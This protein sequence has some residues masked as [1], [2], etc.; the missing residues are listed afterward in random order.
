MKFTHLVEINT[1]LLPL[2]DLLSRTQLWN[3]LVLRMQAP[4]LFV[5]YLDDCQIS[6]QTDLHFARTLRFGEVRI[7]D[8]VRL[9]P[10]QEIHVD[11]PAQNEMPASRLMVQIEEPHPQALFVR[12]TYDDAQI[13]AADSMQANYDKFRHSAYQEADIDTIRL[14]R[15]MAGE[16]RLEKLPS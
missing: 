4:T 2:V 12:F 15:Q 7:R 3:G 10:Q 1:P 9:L 6:D 11:V 14:I 5:P 16:G 13:A 8:Q